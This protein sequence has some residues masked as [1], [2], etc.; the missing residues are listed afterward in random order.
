MSIIKGII[1]ISLESQ[2]QQKMRRLE[3]RYME[4]QKEMNQTQ[5][6]PWMVNNVIFCYDREK[7]TGIDSG[8]NSTSYNTKETTVISRK[9]T[10]TNQ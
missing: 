1:R 7:H 10:L 2:P 3:Q 5:Q 4:K 8:K 9:S 6:P